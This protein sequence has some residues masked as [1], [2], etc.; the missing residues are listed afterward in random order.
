[1]RPSLQATRSCSAR[2]SL[3]Q[4]LHMKNIWDPMGIEFPPDRTVNQCIFR[5]KSR[6]TD[7]DKRHKIGASSTGF[8][9]MLNN[10]QCLLR[11]PKVLLGLMRLVHWRVPNVKAKG[12]HTLKIVPLTASLAQGVRMHRYQGVALLPHCERTTQVFSA[13]HFT[14]M[15]ILLSRWDLTVR[16]KVR[17]SEVCTKHT[18]VLTIAHLPH[19][20]KRHLLRHAHG[21]RRGHKYR[22]VWRYMIQL[23][24]IQTSEGRKNLVQL[25]WV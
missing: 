16:K 8:G 7:K 9:N 10:Q 25:S 21:N 12:Y 4:L 1:M 14:H 3:P 22:L 23:H 18:L 15:A 6:N 13:L 2:T 17:T 5:S 11:H 24:R 19:R 20:Q